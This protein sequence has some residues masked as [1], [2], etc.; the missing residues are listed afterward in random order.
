MAYRALTSEEFTTG[1]GWEESGLEV[2]ATVAGLG[3]I[4]G[5]GGT[6]GIMG[7]IM[8]FMGGIMG[9]MGGIMG[10]MGVIEGMRN[11]FGA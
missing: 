7:G 1:S 2:C 11:A 6:G 5:M 4:D 3:A 8:V 9:G 10:V